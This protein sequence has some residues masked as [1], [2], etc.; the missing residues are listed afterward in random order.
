[1]STPVTVEIRRET[2]PERS[3]E[4]V[5]WL[6]H[7]MVLARRF[8]GYLGGG[9]LRDTEDQNV[10]HA[11]Y[12]FRDHEA[13]QRWE[14]SEERKQ[15]LSS[16]EPFV[17]A[18]R[19]QRRTGIEGWFDGPR[20]QQ[21]TDGETGTVRTIGVRSAPQRWKQTCAIWIGMFPMN[22]LISWLLSFLPW[23]GDMHLAL[24]VAL[25]VTVLA[26]LMTFAV[27]PVVTR[28]LRPWLR[29]NPGVI[30]S[31]RALNEALDALDK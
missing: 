14:D 21:E 7:G 1:M 22:L 17:I 11:V 2:S 6:D 16:G 31:E 5:A 24:R 27:M 29:R 13:C 25:L 10:L 30:R 12:R 19:T 23:W 8:D 9:V 15:W 20:L 18:E 26:P 4:A 3:G 28:V